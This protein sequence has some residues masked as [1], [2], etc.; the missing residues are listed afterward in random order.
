MRDASRCAA[1]TTLNRTELTPSR[2]IPLKSARPFGPKCAPCNRINNGGRDLSTTIRARNQPPSRPPPP[3][4]RDQTLRDRDVALPPTVIFRCHV[5]IPGTP[6]APRSEREISRPAPRR[7]I[8]RDF[9]N[10]RFR[11]RRRPLER[12]TV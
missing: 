9:R 1:G 4:S 5:N 12:R 7:D 2:F 6:P 3:S 10:R 8:L 11:P